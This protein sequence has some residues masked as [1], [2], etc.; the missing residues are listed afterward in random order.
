MVLVRH[1]ARRSAVLVLLGLAMRAVP[2][3][4]IL[5]MRY[6]GVLQRI[7]LVYFFAA[8]A[9]VHLGLRARARLTL[10]L[11]FGY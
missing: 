5:T 7:G 11:L 2:D 10:G 4:D 9:Y 1:I 3:F 6:Y 8:T